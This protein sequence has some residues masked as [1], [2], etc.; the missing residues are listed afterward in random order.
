VYQVGAPTVPFGCQVL[1]P[2]TV[3]FGC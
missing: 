2:E 3:P 1:A